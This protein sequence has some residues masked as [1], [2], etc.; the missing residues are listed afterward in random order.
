MPRYVL[1]YTKPSK[2][3][4]VGNVI[5]YDKE[6]VIGIFHRKAPLTP[7]LKPGQLVIARVLCE[8][9]EG[10]NFYILYPEMIVEDPNI[11]EKYNRNLEVWGR[12]PYRK[13]RKLR[14]MA[15]EERIGKRR[16]EASKRLK[17]VEDEINRLRS[18]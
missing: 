6:G 14:R 7:K 9:G 8:K 13:L 2:K 18:L 16:E 15:R 3:K 17:E 4:E 5:T 1:V 12:V 10:R 11:P